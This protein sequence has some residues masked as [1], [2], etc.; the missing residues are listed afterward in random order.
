MLST[1]PEVRRYNRLVDHARIHDQ[2]RLTEALNKDSL[3]RKKEYPTESSSK[4]R[5]CGLELQEQRKKLNGSSSPRFLLLLG[6]FSTSKNPFARARAGHEDL[7]GDKLLLDTFQLERDTRTWWESVEATKA[8]VQFTWNKFKEAFNAKYFSERV[9]ERKATEFSALNQRSLSVA[10]YE[11]Q[12][13]RLICY[14]NHLVNTERMK[15]KRF[16][17]GL[18]PQYITQLGPLDIQTYVEMVK[19]AQLLEDATDYIERI[20][21][22]FIKKEMTPSSSSSKPTNGKK[23]PFSI[24]EGSS[25]E[26]KPK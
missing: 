16:L 17:N 7:R 12:F 5:E 4:P 9:Q 1:G 6:L 19:M 20:K 23:R 11:A 13:S 3:V 15:A 21:G 10:E 2:R 8:D 26:K 25:Q 24:T 14:A 18:K 22:R